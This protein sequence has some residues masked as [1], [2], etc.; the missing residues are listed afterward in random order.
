MRAGGRGFAILAVV[1][2]A[3][4]ATV[5]WV[6]HSQKLERL[7]MRQ[8]VLQDIEKLERIGK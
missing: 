1:S 3:T 7:T 4:V 8:A 2:A 5:G 6:H